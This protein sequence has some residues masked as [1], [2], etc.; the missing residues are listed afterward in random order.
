MFGFSKIMVQFDYLKMF[1]S[2]VLQFKNGMLA[3]V[4]NNDKLSDHFPVFD[5]IKQSL[6]CV[7]YFA[8]LQMPSRIVKMVHLI[9]TCSI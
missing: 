5:G 2:V 9:Q 1:I 3:C 8:M 4:Q 7:V 6:V